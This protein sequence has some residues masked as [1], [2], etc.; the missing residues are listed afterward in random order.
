MRRLPP[1]HVPRPR[2]S[3]LCAD[4]QVVVIEA[5][6]GYGKSVLGAELTDSWLAV[7]IEV[8][9]DHGEVPAELLAARLRT[10][11]LQAGFSE[12][13]ATAAECEDDATAAV[14]SLLAALADE[15]CA[16]VIDDSHNARKDAGALI[17]HLATHLRG[18]QRLVVLARRLPE[19]AQRLRRAECLHLSSVELSMS[20]EETL[21]LCRTGFGL[22]VGP[23]VA[24]AIDRTTGGWTAATVLAVARATR[25][26][27][28][29]E[30]LAAI[31][32]SGDHAGALAALLEEAVTNL[33]PE[34]RQ[35]LAQLAR[36]PLLDPGLVD[37]VAEEDGFFEASL[38]AGL[39][40]VPANGPW[41]DLPGPVRDHLRTFSPPIHGAMRRA[42]EEYRRR[43]QLGPALQMLL[44]SG[45]PREAASLLVAANDEDREGLDAL[46]LQSVLDQLPIEVIEADPA[47]L[48][49]VAKGHGV[50][51]HYR[52]RV[53]LIERAAALAARSGDEVLARAI[54]AE[55]ANDLCRE[56]AYDE[57]ERTARTVL[58]AA[59]DEERFTRA[60]CYYTL[61]R[62]LLLR[63]KPD[64]PR[65]EPAIAE[66]EDCFGRCAALYGGL[67][68]RSAQAVILVETANLIDYENG[69]AETA[70]SRLDAALELAA[71]RPRRWA[72]VHCFRAKVAAELGLGDACRASVDA[73]LR[74]A[75]QY[76]DELFRAYGHRRLAMLAA[77]EGDAEATLHHVREAERHRADNWWSQASATFLAEAADWLGRVGHTALAWEYLARAMA[78]PKDAR[79]E[80]ALSE[81]VLEARDG[82]P[83][84]AAQR[85]AAVAGGPVAP[86]ELW[87]ITLARA[88]A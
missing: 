72:W 7:G 57:C 20:P 12:A 60:R 8:Q 52:Q 6:G 22:A 18:E 41:W 13:A 80:V 85:L 83:V 23:E 74:V 3:G 47:V 21:Q 35:L 53:A 2:L 11:A 31:P 17:E 27:D 4:A 48:L 44:A 68:L 28:L 63:R 55:H 1:Y 76:D 26:G 25:T 86:R 19:G 9:L 87:R 49:V 14:D 79:P 59:G 75:E 82:D 67:G 5:A 32:A 30:T 64:S 36:L 54:A 34:R 65:D 33:G 66:A 42:A 43:G 58:A 15:R 77:Y 51:F 78:D 37:L 84:L 71:E 24:S 10:A 62:A 39:P 81:A 50:A 70:L 29:A 69:R 40:F 38:S 88:Y 73:V 46:E 45:E 61:A 16:F 56:F